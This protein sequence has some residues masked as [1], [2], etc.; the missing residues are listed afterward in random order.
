VPDEQGGHDGGLEVANP[1]ARL[2]DPHRARRNGNQ[3]ALYG[4][5]PQMANGAGDTDWK[6]LGI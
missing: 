4:V 6:G 1:T 2:V 3:I 5:S